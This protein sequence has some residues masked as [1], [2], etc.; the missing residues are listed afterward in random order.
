MISK[1][2]WNVPFSPK[3][4]VSNITINRQNL[5]FMREFNSLVPKMEI[6]LEE[7]HRIPLIT[8]V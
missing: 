1:G 6:F 4:N 3:Q 5:Y 7:L 8:A 2:T